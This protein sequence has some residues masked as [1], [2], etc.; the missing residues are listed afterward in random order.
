MDS[1]INSYCCKENIIIKH[2]AYIF[3]TFFTGPISGSRALNKI[4]GKA[5]GT[6]I[7]ESNITI[8]LLP[9]ISED[10]EAKLKKNANN[11][12]IR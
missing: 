5:T 9:I 6:A 1:I 2:A 11:P 4:T 8:I 7:A 3:S 10:K 12:M